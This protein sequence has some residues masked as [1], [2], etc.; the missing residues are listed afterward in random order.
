[1]NIAGT[2]ST[3]QQATQIIGAHP[4]GQKIPA[5]PYPVWLRI[6]EAIW[7]TGISRSKLYELI[8]DRK[9]RS[10]SLRDVGQS[11]AT[12][13]ISSESLLNFIDSH[14]TGGES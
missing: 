5:P 11:K 7:L 4:E 13:V 9:V 14:A 6:P 3:S 12:R 10:A 2:N 8:R 1:M